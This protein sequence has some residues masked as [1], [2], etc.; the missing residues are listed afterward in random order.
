MCV[1]KYGEPCTSYAALHGLPIQYFITSDGTSTGNRNMNGDYSAA[2]TDFYFTATADFDIYSVLVAITD[3]ANFNYADYGGITSGV[4][5]NGVKFFVHP[6]AAGIDVPLLA[7]LA[8][9]HN[10]DWLSVS[11]DVLLTTFAGTSQTLSIEVDVTRKYGRPLSIATGDKFIVRLHDNFTGL[12]NHTVH[13]RGIR[14]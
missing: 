6:V 2:A 9:T 1:S 14:H 7:G 3:N 10:Y 13:L 8:L 12:V 5:T 4:I 11:A